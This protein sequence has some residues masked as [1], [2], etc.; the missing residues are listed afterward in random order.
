MHMQHCTVHGLHGGECNR[1]INN[2]EAPIVYLAGTS[3][4]YLSLSYIM[5]GFGDTARVLAPL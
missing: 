1:P 4:L 3:S 2:A 5:L